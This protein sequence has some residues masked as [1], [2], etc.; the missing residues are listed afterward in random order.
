MTNDQ[1]IFKNDF[2]EQGMI[3]SLKAEYSE[4]LSECIHRFVGNDIRAYTV[5][6]ADTI[7]G[8]AIEDLTEYEIGTDMKNIVFLVFREELLEKAAK[9]EI[10]TSPE[11]NLLWRYISHSGTY[12]DCSEQD[13]NIIL[14]FLNRKTFDY[15]VD[16]YF[17]LKNIPEQKRLERKIRHAFLGKGD[18]HMTYAVKKMQKHKCRDIDIIHYMRK[19]P[20]WFLCQIGNGK[21]ALVSHP[22][23]LDHLLLRHRFAARRKALPLVVGIAAVS[24]AYLFAKCVLHML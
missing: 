10:T 18:I 1:L 19:M 24:L 21:K 4:Y 13:L 16:R 12:E 23:S 9:G 11:N 17:F 22:S 6:S 2:L 7:F 3:L 14:S 15:L 8:K 20:R 5:L